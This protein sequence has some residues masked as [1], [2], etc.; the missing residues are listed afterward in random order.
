MIDANEV[1]NTPVTREEFEIV[2]KQ[3]AEI[4]GFLTGVANALKSPMLR[5]M[6]PP[7]FRDMLG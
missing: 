1:K 7:Q 5:S 4:H 3:V 6:L 2:A